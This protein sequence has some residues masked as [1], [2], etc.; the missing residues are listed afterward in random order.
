MKRLL[1]LLP[2]KSYRA[3]DFLRAAERLGIGLVIG[4]ERRQALEA[5]VPGG[6]LQLDLDDLATAE[7]KIIAF[8]Q[9]NP[10]AGIVGADD[11]TTLL[12][13]AAG[14]A[15]GMPHNPPHSA[16]LANNKLLFRQA[17]RRAGLP[18]PE[19]HVFA[20]SDDPRRLALQPE[21]PCVLKPTFL[22]GS[23]GVLRAD[24]QRQFVAAFDRIRGLLRQPAVRRRGGPQAEEL[25]VECYLP[26]TEHTLEGLLSRGRL[27]QLALFDKPDPLQGPTFEETIYLTPSGL[28][29]KDQRALLDSTTAAAAAIGLQE[30]PVHAELRM[31]GASA[32]VLEIATRAI[33][34]LCPRALRF[35]NGTSLEEIILRHAI[36]APVSQLRRERQAAGVMMIPIPAAGTLQAVRGLEAA[37]SVAGVDEVTISILEGQQVEPL[38]EGDRYLGFIFARAESTAEVEAGLRR[39]HSQLQFGIG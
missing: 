28:S 17:M 25:L 23:R 30:G 38:P 36:G 22:S 20:L 8:A 13:A 19:F 9:Q 5:E 4:C 26:G 2:T 24:N 15:L 6:T 12:A 39:A 7:N 32:T 10:L 3:H 11:E 14:R 35:D 31:D 27:Q 37:R 33:G 16:E 1:L 21:Y 29:E 34:G 18:G